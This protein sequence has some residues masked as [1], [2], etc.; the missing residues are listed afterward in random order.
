LFAVLG[1][2]APAAATVYAYTDRDGVM[3]FTNIPDDLRYRPYPLPGKQ[4]T[5]EWQD[6]V[7]RLRRVHRVDI[8]SYDRLIVEAAAYYS[9]PAA[10]VK[11]VV[12][13]E[14]SF[15]PAAVSHAGAQGLMQ[16]IP[17]TARAMHV[18]DS[19]DP[20]DNIYGGT[21]YLRVLANEFTGDVRLTLAAYNAGPERVRRVGDVPNIPETRRY[22]RRVLTLYKHYL[23]T[24]KPGER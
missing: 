8:D 12:A 3:H 24:W 9:L 1:V 18:Q 13:V 22:V 20:R 4:N 5:F 17:S 21:R 16:L 6:D 2:A 15:E 7:G 19:F 14:S 23:A 11:A 10:L